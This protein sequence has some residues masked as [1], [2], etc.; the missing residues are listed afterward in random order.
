MPSNKPIR[1]R[2]FLQ[3]AAAAAAAPWIVPHSVLASGD[4]PGANDR[5]ALAIIGM[6]VRGNQLINN[7]PS[8]G[9]L[10]AICDCDRRCT[11]AALKCT[12]RTGRLTRTTASCWT[13]K[14]STP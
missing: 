9:R 6:G 7:I 2:A 10:T 11:A 13:E 14:T 1:R 4:R 8:D 5:I 3:R 12:R